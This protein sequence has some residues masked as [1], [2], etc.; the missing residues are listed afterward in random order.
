[1]ENFR[2][3]EK[4]RLEYHGVPFFDR[5]CSFYINDI[6]CENENN[7]DCLFADDTAIN[8]GNSNSNR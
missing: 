3:L 7:T 5:C 6:S 8:H 4:C 2:N 1:M